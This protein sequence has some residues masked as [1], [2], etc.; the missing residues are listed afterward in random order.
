MARRL[1][2]PIQWFGGKYY[3][4]GKLIELFPPHQTYV[5]PFGGGGSLIIAKDP[6]PVEI[7]NDLDGDLVNFFRVVRDREGMFPDLY[8]RACCSP[9][10]RQEYYFCRD[11]LNDDPDPVERARRFFVLARFSFSGLVGKS[12]GVNV[13]A[14]TRGMTEKAAAYGSALCML[15]LIADRLMTISIENRHFR[16]LIPLYDR[17]GTLFYIDPPYL[18]ETRR[19]GGYTHEMTR[20]DHEELVDL[21]RGIQGKA[22]LSGYPND[23]YDRL[24]WRRLDWETTCRASGRTRAN[25]LQGAGAVLKDGRQK[26]TECVWMSWEADEPPDA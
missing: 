6:S 9:Y 25:G 23:L 8:N 5:E 26:R 10:S 3:L 15:P 1:R 13:T 21:L 14:S 24:G 7:Y 17:P 4:A 18:P 12:F 22:M 2:S 16:D 19:G 11:H 20:E